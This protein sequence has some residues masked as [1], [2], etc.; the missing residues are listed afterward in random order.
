MI[1]LPCETIVYRAITRA[2]DFRDGRALASA[3]HRRLSDSDG[4]SVNYAVPV[5]DGCA[6]ELSGKRAIVSL[7]VGK[8]RDVQLDVAADTETHAAI[9]GLPHYDQLELRERAEQLAALLA[10]MARTIWSR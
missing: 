5:P 1:E 3:F 4:L 6:P 8:M 7:H 9:V 2:R 10:E